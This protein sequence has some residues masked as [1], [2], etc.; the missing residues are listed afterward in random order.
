M[1]VRVASVISKLIRHLTDALLMLSEFVNLRRTLGI[2]FQIQQLKA[3]PTV[4]R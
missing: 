2:K 4:R 1:V 3:T